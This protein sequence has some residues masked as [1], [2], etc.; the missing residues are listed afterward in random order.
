MLFLFGMKPSCLIGR[1]HGFTLV[2]LLV[3]I[4]IIGILIA[5]L[6]PAVQAA[7]EAAR[8]LQCVNN[9][10]QLGLGIHNYIS[11][12]DAFPLGAP[13]NGADGGLGGHAGLGCCGVSG[14][15]CN[16]TGYGW[17]AVILPYMELGDAYDEINFD[18]G[19]N[20]YNTWRLRPLQMKYAF[21]HCPSAPENGLVPCCGNYFDTQG[22][23]HVGETN[24]VGTFTHIYDAS[25][26]DALY[27]YYQACRGSGIMIGGIFKQLKI[28]DVVDGTSKTIMVTEKDAHPTQ[29]Y[30][31]A[32]CRAGNDCTP[33]YTWLGIN[34]ITTYGGI[35][36]DNDQTS[37][38]VFSHHPGGANFLYADGHVEFHDE[39]MDSLELARI[40][41]RNDNSL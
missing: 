36:G 32:L 16:Y 40:T 3:V 25:A 6:L 31:R 33:G 29:G 15:E 10:K 27:G 39:L 5:L 8:R 19:F 4:A 23:N 35:N 14:S 12:Y 1:R 24:Y 11:T 2:E 34:I 26:G 18:I 41:T 7:R 21:Y 22:N 13:P 9:L 38:G 30:M 37:Y 17:S 28:R 20:A